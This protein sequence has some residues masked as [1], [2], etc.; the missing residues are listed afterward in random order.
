VPAGV[1][2][3]TTYGTGGSLTLA[4][5]LV[6]TEFAADASGKL[7]AAGYLGVPGRAFGALF[8]LNPDG[9]PDPAF[10]N[11][12]VATLAP[13][14]AGSSL[15]WLAILPL[16]DG[17]I[18]VGGLRRQQ[19][20]DGTWQERPALA[21][22][23]GD[24]TLDKAFGGEGDDDGFVL[25]AGGAS[26]GMITSLALLPDGKVLA[27]GNV[28][29]PAPSDPYDFGL[30]RFNP[31]GTP[32]TT[33]GAGGFR[34]Q[35]LHS[36][37]YLGALVALS[38][39]SFIVMDQFGPFA[40]NADGTLRGP[41]G[42]ETS[43]IVSLTPDNKLVVVGV[44]SD[45]GVE[46][47]QYT[48]TVRR[49]LADGSPDLTFGSG[50][51]GTTTLAIGEKGD[52]PDSLTVLPDGS[53]L[54]SAT[55]T[56]ARYGQHST[57]VHLAPDGTPDPGFGVNGFLTEPYL[58]GAS[59]V[60]PLGGGRLV[61]VGTTIDHSTPATPFRQTLIA[62]QFAP[63]IVVDPGGPYGPVLEGAGFLVADAG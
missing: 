30:W 54:V 1:A 4:P 36:D 48:T 26:D 28:L 21:R 18:V 63:G 42:D 23:N 49:F 35:D 9:S 41:L 61:T 43:R 11:G 13:P 27:G 38:D 47:T 57:L 37:D 25:P 60:I 40:F 22:Y 62:H 14:A 7:L 19:L 24:G 2:V 6:G 8:R 3:D 50:A 31:D 15:R 16:P 53:L 44:V 32:D 52:F 5:E 17:G 20:A 45:G 59:S 46:N 56:D 34:Q 12:Q 29:A 58:G 10:N 55:S 51:N 39:G 33:F